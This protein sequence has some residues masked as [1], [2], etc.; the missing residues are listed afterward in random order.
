MP[1]VPK[2]HHLPERPAAGRDAGGTATEAGLGNGPGGSSRTTAGLRAYADMMDSGIESLGP[3]PAHWEV[4]RLQNVT[5][6]RVSNVDKHMKTGERPVRLCNYVDVYKNDFIQRDLPFMVATATTE[7]ID[8]FRLNSEDVLITK[9]SEAWDD[10]GVPALVKE[11]EDDVVSGYHLALLRPHTEIFKGEYLF[12]ALQCQ[13]VAFQF[14]VRANGVTR[15]G[16]SHQAIKSVRLPVPPLREQ[17]TIVRFL[18]HADRRIRRYIRAKEK[19]IALLEEQKQAIIHEAIMGQ[20]DVRTG[21]PYPA[22]NHSGTGWL[23]SI[24]RH[25]EAAQLRRVTIARCDGPFG[26]GLK[27]SHYKGEGVR[28]IRLQNIGHGEFKNSDAAY[29]SQEHYATLGDHSVVAGDLLIAGLGD[30]NHPTGRACV[31]PRNIDPAM[32]K[33][34]CFRFRLIRT[35]ANPHFVAIQLSSTARTASAVLAT[36][37]TRQR[38]NLENTAAR[39]IAIPSPEEQKPIVDYL[40]T[41]TSR[42]GSSQ[43]IIQEQIKL[44]NDF[45]TRLIADVVTGKLDVRSGTASLPNSE[46]GDLESA[47]ADDPR[48]SATP[49]LDEWYAAAAQSEA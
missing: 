14:H 15:Y 31:A 34:D 25:W 40:T 39:T 43:D 33:A 23:G 13:L 44:M 21:R 28:V 4:R 41:K 24:P 10:I 26:S 45:G 22:Y 20:I 38:V 30:N 12:R 2:L 8:R 5:E 42:I 32:V 1:D 7:E 3:V 6:M 35:R 16:L 29:I 37:A 48:S 49:E 9:D 17:S 46:P 19:L 18:D 36:G 47:T 11:I 27:S